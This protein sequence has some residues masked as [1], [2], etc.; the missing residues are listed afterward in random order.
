MVLQIKQRQWHQNDLQPKAKRNVNRLSLRKITKPDNSY[1]CRWVIGDS[2]ACKADA[3][4]LS[5]ASPAQG[6]SFLKTDCRLCTKNTKV[7]YIG[8]DT[9]TLRMF[10][11]TTR[12]NTAK[13]KTAHLALIILVYIY[14]IHQL[15]TSRH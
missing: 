2:S 6:H 3:V 8:H 1:S 9:L 12:D 4:S 15:D 7:I 13:F 11:F 5:A 14:F 10:I